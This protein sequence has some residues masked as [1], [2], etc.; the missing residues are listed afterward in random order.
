[1]K[2]CVITGTI[3]RTEIGKTTFSCR[4]Y[5]SKMSCIVTSLVAQHLRHCLYALQSKIGHVIRKSR[6]VSSAHKSRSGRVARNAGDMEVLE[7][8][9]GARETVADVGR[10]G[11]RVAVAREIAVAHVVGEEEQHIGA[12]PFRVGA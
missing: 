6:R 2:W 5:L 8:C 12:F 10:L 9:A 7:N 3:S 4:N 1:M 11:V